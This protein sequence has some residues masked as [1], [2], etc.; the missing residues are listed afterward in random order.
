MRRVIIS[1]TVMPGYFK[2]T[3]RFFDSLQT[4]LLNAFGFSE[5]NFRSE[6]ILRL[7]SYKY[8]RINEEDR[9]NVY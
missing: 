8:I 5:K 9:Q 6:N 4:A 2:M 1:R 7:E 3:A